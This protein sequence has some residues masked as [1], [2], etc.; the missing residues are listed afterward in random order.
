MIVIYV[1][2]RVGGRKPNSLG[3]NEPASL[4]PYEM[5]AHEQED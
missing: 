1:T 3:S 4:F 2:L 5:L